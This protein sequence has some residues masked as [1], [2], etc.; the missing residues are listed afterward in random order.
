METLIQELKI[1]LV[2]IAV[3]LFIIVVAH[4]MEGYNNYWQAK[5]AQQTFEKNA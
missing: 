1:P 4:L 2:L 5:V 3:F